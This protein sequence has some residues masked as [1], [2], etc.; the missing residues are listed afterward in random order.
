MLDGVL[1]CD[2]A[3]I[4]EICGRGVAEHGAAHLGASVVF[5]VLFNISL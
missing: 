3:I 4:D 5:V 2:K 1:V